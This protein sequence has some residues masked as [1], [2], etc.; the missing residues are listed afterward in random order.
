VRYELN[1]SIKLRLMLVFKLKNKFRILIIKYLIL[2][3]NSVQNVSLTS[4]EPIYFL[5]FSP[6][7]T[8]TGFS[9]H[10]VFSWVV[11]RRK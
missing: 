3:I 4:T 5:P 11:R 10:R 1:L 8:D 2:L 6:P 9:L 7:K